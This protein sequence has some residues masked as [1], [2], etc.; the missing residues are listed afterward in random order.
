MTIRLDSSTATG[1]FGWRPPAVDAVTHAIGR[2]RHLNRMWGN[3]TIPGTRIPVFRLQE[4]IAGGHTAEEI[5]R[6][7]Y[8]GRI[9]ANQVRRALNIQIVL[10]ADVSA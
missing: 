7:L 8:D 9:T 3:P 1:S 6:D 10:R 5:A 4:L 2:E